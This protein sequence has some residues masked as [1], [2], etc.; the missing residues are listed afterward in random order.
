MSRLITTAE[1]AFDVLTPSA[2]QTVCQETEMGLHRKTM[3]PLSR[4]LNAEIVECF[5]KPGQ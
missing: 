2:A 3:S 4:D 1:T 5:I